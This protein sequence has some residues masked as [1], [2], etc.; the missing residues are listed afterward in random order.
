[1]LEAGKPLA[2]GKVE[3]FSNMLRLITNVKDCNLPLGQ[4]KG[5]VSGIVATPGMDEGISKITNKNNVKELL[6]MEEAWRL[7]FNDRVEQVQSQHKEQS[8]HLEVVDDSALFI[9]EQIRRWSNQDMGAHTQVSSR[10]ARS[11]DQRG[12]DAN[13]EH[14]NDMDCN[15]VQQIIEVRHGKKT[16]ATVNRR[17]SCSRCAQC[18]FCQRVA[19]FL[20][21]RGSERRQKRV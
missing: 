11:G 4:D 15:M 19:C 2:A 7:A 12:A 13:T 16:G 14:V 17:I 10:V 5:S 9:L 1:M 8:T 21:R 20:L 6:P 3:V 18:G